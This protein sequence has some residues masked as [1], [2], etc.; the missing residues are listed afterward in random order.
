[1]HQRDDFPQSQPRFARRLVVGGLDRVW[2]RF[3]GD[4]E[5]AWVA[6]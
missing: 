5:R 1:M 2:G 4:P 6:A 3:E